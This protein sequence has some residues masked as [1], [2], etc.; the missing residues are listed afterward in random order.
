M[1]IEDLPPATAAAV[2]RQ[3]VQTGQPPDGYTHCLT[4]GF[5][6][7]LDTIERDI[8]ATSLPQGFGTVR[9]ILG[10]NGN[11][12]THL[13]RDIIERARARGYA[14]AELDLSPGRELGTPAALYS[15][16]ASSVRLANA[17]SDAAGIDRILQATPSARSALTS[18]LISQAYRTAA[19]GLTDPQMPREKRAIYHSWIRGEAVS[20][21]DRKSVALK[22]RL[23][24]RNALRWVKNLILT[25]NGLGAQGL[26]VVLDET[27]TT[28]DAAQRRMRERLTVML[29]I[30]NGTA[31]GNFPRT[32]FLITGITNSFTQS[33]EGLRPIRQRLAPSLLLQEGSRVNPRGIRIHTDGTGE[34]APESWMQH[35]NQR[36]LVLGGRAGRSSTPTKEKQLAD[37]VLRTAKSAVSLNKRTFIREAAR[38]VDER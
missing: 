12:K 6:T 8:L 19:R 3:L 1:R 23:T 29:A 10:Q 34:L 5:E 21:S 15:Q 17:P 20:S 2:L 27:E 16:I 37:L 24:D 7:T 30:I 28:L 9:V 18:R 33:W 32:L 11:G 13:C 38:I 4:V 35:A 22:E 14:T 36:L 26:V 25:V 31:S